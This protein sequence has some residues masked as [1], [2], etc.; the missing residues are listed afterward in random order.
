M[1]WLNQISLFVLGFSS[2]FPLINPIGTALIVNPWFKGLLPAERRR[3]S[4]AIA[5][6]SFGLG[7]AALFGGSWVLKFMGISVASTQMAGGLI[8]GRMGLALLNAGPKDDEDRDGRRSLGDS[9]FYPLAFPL[10]LGPGGVSVLITLSA[11][12]HVPDPAETFMRMAV[13]SISLLGTLIIT[14]FCFVYSEVV[15]RRIGSSGSLVMNRLMAF[16]VFCIGIQMFVA[17]L[18]NSFPRLFS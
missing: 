3:T 14:W 4:L 1:N 13:L 18:Q 5:L 12:A 11:H 8:I 15:I 6:Y 16:I 9:L 7:L 17:G 10:T 2:L